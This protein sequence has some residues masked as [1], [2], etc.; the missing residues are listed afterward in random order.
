[1]ILHHV[2]KTTSAC[3]FNASIAN[4][5]EQRTLRDRRNTSSSALAWQT[6]PMHLDHNLRPAMAS[7]RMVSALLPVFTRQA[8]I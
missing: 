1:M 7:L 2:Q 4:K 5:F 3:Q 6:I 8:V